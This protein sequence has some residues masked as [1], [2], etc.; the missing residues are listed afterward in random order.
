M[1]PIDL[2]AELPAQKSGNHIALGHGHGTGQTD[3][4]VAAALRL[5]AT[6]QGRTCALQDD[7]RAVAQR[8]CERDMDHPRGQDHALAGDKWR[9]GANRCRARRLGEACEACLEHEAGQAVSRDRSDHLGVETAGAG[10]DLRVLETGQ[11]RLAVTLS[12][13]CA[14]T[15]PLGSE[16]GKAARRWRNPTHGIAMVDLGHG[17]SPFFP[18]SCEDAGQR[19]L[20]LCDFTHP[21]RT[22]ARFTTPGIERNGNFS[23]NI[24][25]ALRRG[26]ADRN[27]LRTAIAA[28]PAAL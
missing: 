28:G 23:V 12:R 27:A 24:R 13:F 6:P 7:F 18:N 22:A 19:A 26:G 9:D 3:A 15:E 21:G 2:S 5:V 17:G 8:P 25:A 11:F 16:L 1:G 4:K 20:P 10:M 14:P